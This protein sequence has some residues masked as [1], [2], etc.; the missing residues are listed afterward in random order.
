MILLIICDE[1]KY[2]LLFAVILISFAI[3]EEFCVYNISDY[4]KLY[5]WWRLMN[6]F[7]YFSKYLNHDDFSELFKVFFY[8]F[9]TTLPRQAEN[10]E[11]ATF[12]FFDALGFCRGIFQAVVAFSL[13]LCKIMNTVIVDSAELLFCKQMETKQNHKNAQQPERERQ[14]YIHT[15]TVH[16]WKEK[17]EWKQKKALKSTD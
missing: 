7:E 5:F 17:R 13:V 15:D 4:N 10:D 8:I 14:W 3:T 16:T 2:W 1:S 11:V 12:S 6:R 9:F